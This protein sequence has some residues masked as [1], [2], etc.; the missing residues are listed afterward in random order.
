LNL[1]AYDLVE[2]A[3]LAGLALYAWWSP[4][5]VPAISTVFALVVF[6]GLARFYIG[7][8]GPDIEAGYAVA[9]AASIIAGAHLAFTYTT[10]GLITGIAF[11]LIPLF[12]GLAAKGW[13]PIVYQQGPGP[14]YWTLVSLSAWVVW[15][16]VATAIWRARHAVG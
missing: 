1:T 2:I 11:A 5:R 14:D 9:A 15:C 4:I 16:V 6:H 3:A 8:Y 12:T 13:I 10:L 7:R